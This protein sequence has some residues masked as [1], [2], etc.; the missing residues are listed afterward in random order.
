[1]KFIFGSMEE[2]Y[3]A[4][5]MKTMGRKRISSRRASRRDGGRRMRRI[6]RRRLDRLIGSG[7][8]QRWGRNLNSNPCSYD[9]G[10]SRFANP[11]R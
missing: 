8:L 3:L 4:I 5:A 11:S 6:T 2:R 10:T 1:M 7:T 9:S